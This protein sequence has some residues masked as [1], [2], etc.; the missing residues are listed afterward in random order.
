M[1]SA[2]TD[3]TPAVSHRY[4][5][6]DSSLGPSVDGSI[7][8]QSGLT[9]ELAAWPGLLPFADRVWYLMC[10]TLAMLRELKVVT[11]RITIEPGITITVPRTT[12]RDIRRHK[13]SNYQPG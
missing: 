5:S 4:L 10:D 1:I 9:I 3:T 8:K 7:H 2:S 12:S 6:I 13:A 11:Y